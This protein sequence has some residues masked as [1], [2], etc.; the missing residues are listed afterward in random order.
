MTFRTSGVKLLLF[1]FALSFSVNAAEIST[2]MPEVQEAVVRNPDGS[3]H[4]VE[5]TEPKS[6][7]DVTAGPDAL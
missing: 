1:V 6:K 2:Q 3:V 7:F 4:T 5:V